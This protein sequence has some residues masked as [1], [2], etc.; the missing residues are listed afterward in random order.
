MQKE[1]I[2]CFSYVNGHKEA[3]EIV[4]D[5]NAI[6]SDGSGNFYIQYDRNKDYTGDDSYLIMG[7]VTEDDWEEL[8]LDSDFMRI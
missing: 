3:Q 4:T 5:L 1:K 2:I 8:D 6:K 7:C